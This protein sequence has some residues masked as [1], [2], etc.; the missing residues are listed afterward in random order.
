MH[1]PRRVQPVHVE[2]HRVL[3]LTPLNRPNGIRFLDEGK[4]KR[5]SNPISVS[6][7]AGT[8]AYLAGRSEMSITKRYVHP[9]EYSTRAAMEEARVALS[10][11]NFGHR[12]LLSASSA[13]PGLPLSR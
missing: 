6:G 8:L 7:S 5:M 9:R 10:G 1:R 4:G 12:R 3:D 11:H 2:F 13:I